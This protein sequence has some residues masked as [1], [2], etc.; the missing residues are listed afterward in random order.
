LLECIYADP[1]VTPSVRLLLFISRFSTGYLKPEV[2][3]KESFILEQTGMSRSSLYK[4]KKDLLEAGKITLTHTQTGNCVYRLAA[5]LQCLKGA[6]TAQERANRKWGSAPA[7]GGGPRLET[8]H[9]YKEFQENLIDHHQP[10]T[11]PDPTPQHLN[12]DASSINKFKDKVTTG[13]GSVLN[14]M[15]TML[16]ERL[17]ACAVNGRIAENLVRI[18]PTEV[19]E[20]ALTGLKA[21]KEVNNP[22][23]WLVREI[24]S[25]GYVAPLAVRAEESRKI[26]ELSRRA[27]KAAVE[28]ERE[29][30][31][32]AAA[33]DLAELEALAPERQAELL[34]AARARLAWLPRVATATPDNPFIRAAMLDLLREIRLQR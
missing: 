24:Q 19:I 11:K 10:L 9:V 5:D 33:A 29:K 7:D 25:G 21:R 28:V 16:V 22:A 31:D 1:D 23:G 32:A 2:A 3:L 18:S 4:A 17:R 6:T 12:D 30:A 26:V 20:R 34:E 15:Q 14:E 8:P 13:D 27:E